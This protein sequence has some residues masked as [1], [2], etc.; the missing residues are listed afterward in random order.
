MP[1]CMI[2]DSSSRLRLAR[3]VYTRQTLIPSRCVN[4]LLIC[5]R[6]SPGIYDY[7]AK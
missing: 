7:G 6:A 2:G 5:L 3:A 1:S 4:N